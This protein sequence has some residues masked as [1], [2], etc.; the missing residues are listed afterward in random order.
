MDDLDT[1]LQRY[2]AV[3]P[4]PDLRDR[5]ARAAEAPRPARL[6]EWLPA[7]AAVAAT[8]AFYALA[9]GVRGQLEEAQMAPIREQRE[10]ALHQVAASLGGGVDARQEAEWLLWLDEHASRGVAAPAPGLELEKRR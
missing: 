5:I 2:R 1:R 7:L 8:L 3:G 10:I 4:P 6:R 9:A